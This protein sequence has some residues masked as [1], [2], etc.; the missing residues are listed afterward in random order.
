VSE[1][2]AGTTADLGEC[3]V[4]G[5]T[6]GPS[7]LR[8]SS[9]SVEQTKAVGALLAPL[10]EPSDVILLSGSLGTGKTAFTQGLLGALGVTGPIT[11][12]T[13]TLVRTY[14]AAGLEL[15]HADLYRLDGLTQ[16]RDLGLEEDVDQ[17]CVA[18]IEW[19]ER[20]APLFGEDFLE[21]RLE[22]APEGAGGGED[23]RSIVISTRSVPWTGRWSRLREALG[24]Q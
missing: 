16:I 20:A 19:G 14:H 13:F 23:D 2:A 7:A 24:A 15:L 6:V 17:G 9:G 22:L 5:G 21:V 10:L 4:P 1:A 18:L 8:L 3:P 11:S 12:P